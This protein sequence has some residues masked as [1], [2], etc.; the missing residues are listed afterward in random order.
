MTKLPKREADQECDPDVLREADLEREADPDLERG[1]AVSSDRALASAGQVANEY[2]ARSAFA[3]YLSR[4]SDNTIRSQAASLTR[5]ADYLAKVG[6]TAGDLQH[7]PDAWRGVTWGLVEGFRNWMVQ[8]GDAVASVNARLSAVKMYAK[9]ATK[10]GAVTAEEYALIR[11]VAGY[12]SKE[13]NRLNER[14]EVTRRGR[15]KAQHVSI[16]KKQARKLKKQPDTSQGRRDTLIMCLLLDH[17][18]R[19]GEVARLQVSD[20]DLKAGEMHFYR[21]KVDKTQTHKLTADTARAL[22]AWFD[23][24]DAPAVGPL[25]RSSRKNGEL[26]KAGMSVQAITARVR[27]LGKTIGIEGLSAHDCRHYWA[28]FWADKVDVIRL[29]EAGG[30]SSLAM[31]RRYI[32]EADIANEGMA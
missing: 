31:P 12:S 10:T 26:T 28:T 20:F 4:K 5:F 22:Q 30:W 1:L 27:Y 2:A 6:I 16:D 18:L 11:T 14:R 17:G 9:L 29:Q 8:Q 7:D 24:G 13:A 3:D 19:V 15:K 25:L 32:E 23:S 21:P